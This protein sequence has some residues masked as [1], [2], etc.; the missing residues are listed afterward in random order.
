MCVHMNVCG[1]LPLGSNS[2]A[3]EGAE[4]SACSTP[5]R[6]VTTACISISPGGL[7]RL[8]GSSPKMSSAEPGLRADSLFPRRSSDL[9]HRHAPPL[10]KQGALETA[11]VSSL[12]SPSL[13]GF[14]FYVSASRGDAVA[15]SSPLSADLSGTWMGLQRVDLIPHRFLLLRAGC[16]GPGGKF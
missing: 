11:D 14:S 9:Q 5:R 16:G 1:C 12:L 15:P 10:P 8:S 2:Q 13:L 3:R 4:G 7:S 6:V